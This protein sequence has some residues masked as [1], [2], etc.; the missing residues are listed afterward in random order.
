[1]TA[2]VKVPVRAGRGWD[3][4]VLSGVARG[5]RPLEEY[6]GVDVTPR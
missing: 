1:V 6:L 2:A 5:G 3:S 4:I